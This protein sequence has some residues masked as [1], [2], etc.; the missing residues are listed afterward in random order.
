MPTYLKLPRAVTPLYVGRE[1]LGLRLGH[2]FS[3]SP[4]A[5]SKRRKTF[6]IMG[7]GG[8]GKSEACLKYAEDHQEEYVTRESTVEA[9]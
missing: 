2:S 5:S 4:D 6:V 7:L 9:C 1:E 8:T 3:P